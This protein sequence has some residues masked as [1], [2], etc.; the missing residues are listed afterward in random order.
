MILQLKIDMKAT[1][2]KHDQPPKHS[3]LPKS[4]DQYSDLTTKNFPTKCLLF[5]M[6]GIKR[7]QFLVSFAPAPFQLHPWGLREGT[8]SIAQGLLMALHSGII[9]P[10]RGE[11]T[12]G[13]TKGVHDQIWV[14][15]LLGKCLTCYTTA[16]AWIVDGFCLGLL[17]AVYLGEIY[18]TDK[19]AWIR[20]TR[21]GWENSS[22]WKAYF[23]CRMH[24]LD[25]WQHVDPCTLPHVIPLSPSTKPGVVPEHQ[26]VAQ[27]Q[28]T[29][30]SI[31]VHVIHCWPLY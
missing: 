16:P 10:G 14:C 11:T 7:R 26:C 19:L 31:S 8:S 13:T 29:R 21:K 20:K 12:K 15:W 1:T 24:E 6:Y 2:L 3:A 5:R 25:F 27:K 17:S 23:A 4:A 9:T 22:G 18:Y 28:K 30:S